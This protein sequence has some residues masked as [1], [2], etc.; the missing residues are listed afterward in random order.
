MNA[1]VHY[2]PTERRPWTT[3]LDRFDVIGPARCTR[4]TPGIP[5][6][7]GCGARRR[8]TTCR[9]A[10]TAPTGRC[11][12]TRTSCTARCTTRSTPAPA[13]TAASRSRISRRTWSVPASSAWTRRATMSSARW[14]ARSSRRTIWRT[15][16]SLI[17]E[18]TRMV[19]DGL[20]RN[21]TFD[22]VEQVSIKLTTMMLTTLFDFPFEERAKLTYWSDVAICNVN[23]PEAP[24]HSE[25]ER[26]EEIQEDGGVYGPPV[27]GTARSSRR[28][29]T[30]CRCWRT[31]RPRATCRCGS[32]W[33]T[34]CC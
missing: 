25:E 12:N 1:P 13:S 21:E 23:D 9:T 33:A 11:P 20:P 8:F 7:N 10:H 29:S 31:A 16:K 34:W 2:D 14:P 27:H 24:V 6:S 4:T 15:W 18:R 32:S 26:F 5:G 3:P 22:W 30:C 19:L 17:R 28:S